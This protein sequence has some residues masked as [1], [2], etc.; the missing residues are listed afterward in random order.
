[1]PASQDGSERAWRL[2]AWDDPAI[3]DAMLD[4]SVIA[5]SADEIGDVS[6]EPSDEE[7]R[8]RLREAPQLD[9]RSEQALGL[10]VTY[11]RS[12]RSAMQPGEIVIV[13]LRN[14]RAAVGEICGDYQYLPDEAEPR[15]R[16]VRQVRWLATIPRDALDEDLRR[17]VNAPGTICTIGAPGAVDRFRRATR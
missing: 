3:E 7:L 6:A 15:L 16:H 9:G 13:P 1:M 14:G 11:W 8:R 2:R 12:F 17:V 4:R 5:I 10:F